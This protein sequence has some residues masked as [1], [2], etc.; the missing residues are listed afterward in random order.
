VGDKNSHQLTTL[1]RSI[2]NLLQSDFPLVPQPF[3]VLSRRMEYSEWEL[4]EHLRG[5]KEDGVVRGLRG[6][7]DSRRLGYQSTLVAMSVDPAQLDAVADIVNQ[8]AGVSHNYAR[9]HEYNLWFTLMLPL[10][11]SLER[12]VESLAGSYGVRGSISLP[13]LRVFKIDVRFDLLKQSAVPQK[14][15][16]GGSTLEPV[17]VSSPG[18]AAPVL[19]ELE[20]AAVRQLQTDLPLIERPFDSMAVTAGMSVAQLLDIARGFLERG[21]MRRYGAVLSHHRAGYVANAMG[22]WIVPPSRIEEVGRGMACFSAV[23]HCYERPTLADWPYNLFTMIHGRAR[24]ECQ[25]VAA[26]M[27]R[28]TKIEDYVLLYSTREYKKESLKYFA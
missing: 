26:D 19:S 17:E 11:E 24:E 9:E 20:K 15:V 7:F 21:I 5:L 4:I 28:K 22:C 1:D 16:E 13:A 25:S 18:R 8:H 12:A 27:A 14:L 6:I 3:V 23:T 2:L 10:G